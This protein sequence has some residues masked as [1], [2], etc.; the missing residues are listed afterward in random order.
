MGLDR[1]QN[2]TVRTNVGLFDATNYYGRL[3]ARGKDALDLLN[4]M[5]SNDVTPLEKGSGVI[6]TALL[7]EKG[8]FVDLLKVV[9]DSLGETLIICGKDKEQ[10]IISWLDKFTIMEDARFEKATEK[11]WQF[12]LSGPKASE[13]I[14]R[15]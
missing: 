5:S 10:T 11:I 7:N 9:K 12:V 8:R 6:Q 1:A 14:S 13:L 4:R 2:D 3:F 15:H